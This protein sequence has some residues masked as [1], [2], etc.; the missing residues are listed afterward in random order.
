MRRN[1]FGCLALCLCLAGAA[2]AHD[3]EPINTEFASPFAPG[4]GNLQFGTQYIWDAESF[5]T[6]PVEFEMGL[7][8]RTQIA[9]G[10]PVNRL[11]E[12]G[13]TRYGAGNL[14]VAFRYLL[15][16]SSKHRFAISLNP[17]VTIPSGDR[18]VS[19]AAW[20][21]GGA[22]H[23]DTNPAKRLW[24]HTNLGYETTVADFEHREK[25]FFYRFAA[26]FEAAHWVQPVIEL[27]GE[28]EFEERTDLLAA[29]PEV[30]FRPAHDWEV[31]LGLPLGLTGETPDVGAQ[32]QIT[33]K[34]GERE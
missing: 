21:A 29:V 8:P 18:D 12:Y 2:H 16:G 17:E 31:K 6:V 24:T 3:S 26:M 14:E 9:L 11:R 25:T 13:D 4:A 1:L 32:L 20:E 28:H 27:V 23:I 19:E 33:W 5:E 15:A 30:I 22:I 10:F 7:L 34:F